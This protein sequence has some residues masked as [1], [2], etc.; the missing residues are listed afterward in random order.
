MRYPERGAGGFS[1]LRRA[2]AGESRDSPPVQLLEESE[3][4][5]ASESAS[6]RGRSRYRGHQEDRSSTGRKEIGEGAITWSRNLPAVRERNGACRLVRVTTLG[7][8]DPGRVQGRPTDRLCLRGTV[9][10]HHCLPGDSRAYRLPGVAR[11]CS[12]R[13]GVGTTRLLEVT[14]VPY[15]GSHSLKQAAGRG[16]PPH[17]LWDLGWR[18]CRA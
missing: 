2:G 3:Y 6:E 1:S 4:Q 13:D 16:S 18:P 17:R 14:A 15:R 11:V 10:V 7:A 12:S 8:V 9:P 5:T